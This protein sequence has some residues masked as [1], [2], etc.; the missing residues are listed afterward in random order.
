MAR[1]EFFRP[2]HH[3]RDK[4]A[5]KDPD[6]QF[7]RW[8]NLPRSGMANAPGI[9]PLRYLAKRPFTR[10]PAVL[11]LVTKKSTTGGSYN[12]WN[13][14]IDLEQGT[15]LYW[16]D[17]KL[18]PEKR[19]TDFPGN[20]TLEK[21]WA[22]VNAGRREELPPIL[23]FVKHKSGWVTF[24]GLCAL[25]ALWPDRFK[26]KGKFVVN[27][28]CRLRIL[29]SGPVSVSWL[30]SRRRAGTSEDALSGA[31][32][33]WSAWVQGSES[34]PSMMLDAES[35]KLPWAA[36]VVSRS[37]GQGFSS[38]PR[39]RQAVELEAMKRAREYFEKKGFTEIEDV[40][41]HKSFDLH[42]KDG[43]QEV[44][45]EVKGTRTAGSRVFLTRSEVEFARRNKD[46]MA[47]YVF[48]SMQVRKMNEQVVIEGGE[49]QVLC[50]WDVDAGTLDIASIT[51]SYEV[52]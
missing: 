14:V 24:T 38:D 17:A 52:P 8:I 50:P 42:V 46:K 18:H 19:F 49:A 25:T 2:G 13:D 48:H 1:D 44:F 10:L 37:V 21:V 47:L 29:G 9:R 32:D 6:D 22:A 36:D 40:S 31:P 26:E 4:G 5:P 11:V 33:A 43:K 30:H 45:V 35:M 41:R 15:V 12:P 27:Y 20:R 51:Y 34:S 7:M 39:I 3:Y 23:H 28:R 16:G